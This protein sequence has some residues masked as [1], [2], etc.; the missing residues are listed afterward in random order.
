[1][2]GGAGAGMAGD[3]PGRAGRRGGRGGVSAASPTAFPIRHDFCPCPKFLLI[4]SVSIL[5]K[6]PNLALGLG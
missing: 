3:R 6:V 2:D 5:A 1:M 4:V